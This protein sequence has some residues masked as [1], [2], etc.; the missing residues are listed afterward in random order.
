[1]RCTRHPSDLSSSLGV[2]AS[3]LRERLFALIAAQTCHQP[4]T[5]PDE[6]R[7]KSDAHPPPP[8]LFPR[9]AS[10]YISRRSDHDS[11]YQDHNFYYTP[12]AN[13]TTTTSRKKGHRK[14]KFSLFSNLFRSR[15]DDPDSDSRVSTSS[16]SS[17]FSSL[18]SGRRKKK[19]RLCSLDE[20]TPSGRPSRTRD[21]GLGMPPAKDADE[22]G[23][24][25]NHEGFPTE[26]GYSSESSQGWR[27]TPTR[28]SGRRRGQAH[29]HHSRNVSGLAFGL[30]PLV[31]ASPSG[32]RNQKGGPPP[33]IGFSGEIRVSNMP[34]LSTAAS[35]CA[36]R[37]RKLADFG[38]YNFN[39]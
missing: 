30:S 10:P 23:D 19:F 17:W 3:C 1:M 11:S 32:Q 7:R 12:Q 36:N 9:S 35:S 25:E 6:D 37:S 18:L 31:R 14:V 27:K 24:Y 29:A 39:P 38:R 28:Q 5:R 22:D 34:H 26:S 33:D 21:L 2:C 4:L 15:S 20:A 13:P 8:L 16:S